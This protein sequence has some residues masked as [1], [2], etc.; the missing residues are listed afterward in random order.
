[1]PL[2]FGLFKS[3]QGFLHSTQNLHAPESLCSIKKHLVDLFCQRQ[4]LHSG[5]HLWWNMW[6]LHWYQIKRIFK[7][8]YNHVGTHLQHIWIG[9][10]DKLTHS[11][12]LDS[13]PAANKKWQQRRMPRR[14]VV[15]MINK[16]WHLDIFHFFNAYKLCPRC[17]NRMKPVSQLS[18][19]WWG[20]MIVI[21]NVKCK[22]FWL[23][24]EVTCSS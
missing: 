5:Y 15:S 24:S 18:M 17:G 19:Q 22:S 21:T 10:G 13:L 8:S 3:M 4:V 14:W 9:S 23:C 1:M 16:G 7:L 20:H 12:D 11:I 6:S 2:L